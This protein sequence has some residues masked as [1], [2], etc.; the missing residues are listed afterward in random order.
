M[1]YIGRR[2]FMATSMAEIRQALDVAETELAFALIRF[3]NRVFFLQS[4]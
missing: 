1:P 3:C 2:R 4:A